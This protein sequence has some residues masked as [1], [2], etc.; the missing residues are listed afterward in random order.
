MASSIYGT[1]GNGEEE[2][3]NLSRW[4]PVSDLWSTVINKWVMDTRK[5]SV[6]KAV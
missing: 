6:N 5:G 2:L 3:R 4:R 1:A